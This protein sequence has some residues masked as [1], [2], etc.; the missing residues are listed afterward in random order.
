MR[1]PSRTALLL[2]GLLLSL[3]PIT[4][5][6]IRAQEEAKEEPAAEEPAAEPAAEEATPPAEEPAPA[7]AGETPAE[8][9]EKK[10]PAARKPSAKKTAERRP[11]N[12]FPETPSDFWVLEFEPRHMRMISPKSGLGTGRVYGYLVYTLANT[13]K[14]DREVF[15]EISATSENGKQFSDIFLPSVEREIEKKEGDSTLWGKA[16]L[17]ALQKKKKPDDPKYNYMTLK[18]G[19]RRNCVAIFNRLDPNAQ[20]LKIQVA[21]LSNEVRKITKE[22]GTRELEER[23]RE[24]QFERSGDEY[25][26]TLDTFVLTGKAWAKKRVPASSPAAKR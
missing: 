26:I 12:L 15:V 16:D 21:G 14:E 8:P 17:F 19:E 22:D 20:K 1:L 2:A 13:T 6:A 4:A 23:V 18:A 25:A 24:L 3:A 9:A 11:V 10:K 7:D 5:A